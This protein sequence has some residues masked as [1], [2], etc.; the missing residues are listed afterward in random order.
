MLSAV[1]LVLRVL[2]S[3]VA[4][5]IRDYAVLERGDGRGRIMDV[6]ASGLS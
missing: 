5:R 6:V 1:R 4:D 2:C 3:L